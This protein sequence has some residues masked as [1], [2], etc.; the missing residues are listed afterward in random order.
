MP[1]LPGLMGVLRSQ[2]RPQIVIGD[3]YEFQ[4]AIFEPVGWHGH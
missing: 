4:S 3:N 1:R 2:L